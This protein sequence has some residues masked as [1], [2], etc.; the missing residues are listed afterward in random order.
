MSCLPDA[1]DLHPKPAKALFSGAM[2]GYSSTGIDD[3]IAMTSL[4]HIPV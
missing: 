2:V 3:I 1:N 4:V